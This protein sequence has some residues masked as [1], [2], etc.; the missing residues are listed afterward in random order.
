MTKCPQY[1]ATEHYG[2]KTVQPMNIQEL[3]GKIISDPPYSSTAVKVLKIIALW[4]VLLG[5]LFGLTVI[6]DRLI[7]VPSVV[8]PIMFLVGMCV[9]SFG[10]VTTQAIWSE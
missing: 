6:A 3:C 5:G 2:L 9:G 7:G 8:Q 4:V 10:M 1:K